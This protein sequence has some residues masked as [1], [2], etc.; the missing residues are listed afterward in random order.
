MTCQSIGKI[1][2][3]T[4][5]IPPIVN[6][7]MKPDREVQRASSSR[8]CPRHSVAIQLKTLT[9]VG[10]AI[11]IDE[12]MKKASTTVEIGVVNMWCAHT[13]SDRKAMPTVAAAIAL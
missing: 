13:S 3:I 5:E 8:S 1:A 4:P 7:A 10:T 9:P 6:R 12:S 2:S 11:T